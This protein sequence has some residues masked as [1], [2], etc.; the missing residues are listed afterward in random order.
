MDLEQNT[1]NATEPK[2]AKTV[3]WYGDFRLYLLLF[4]VILAFMF[5]AMC[6]RSGFYGFGVGE[7]ITAPEFTVADLDGKKVSLSDFK[8]KVVFLHFWRSDCAPCRRELPHIQQMYR[9]LENRGDFVIMAIANDETVGKTKEQIEKQNRKNTEPLTFPI[10]HDPT[11]EITALF[12]VEAFPATY[13]IDREG[14]IHDYFPQ[15]RN[16]EEK[17]EVTMILD[18]LEQ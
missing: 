4:L 12:K 9:R 5:K 11:G 2:P 14:R 1:K 3:P 13:L 18:L 8:G 17:R 10:Y 16:W 7:K 6:G 15:E